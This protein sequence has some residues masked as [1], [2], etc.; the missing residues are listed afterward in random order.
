M[1]LWWV[2]ND[3]D[4]PCQVRQLAFPHKM[5]GQDTLSANHGRGSYLRAN[6]GTTV[7]HVDPPLGVGVFRLSCPRRLSVGCCW[8][9]VLSRSFI[10]RAFA[11][12]LTDGEANKGSD[13]SNSMSQRFC[14]ACEC[15]LMGLLGL[16]WPVRRL[17]PRRFSPMPGLNPIWVEFST[18]ISNMEPPSSSPKLLP[19]AGCLWRCQT[20]CSSVRLPGVLP[21]LPPP[22][23]LL[24]GV[25]SST[26]EFFLCVP[27]I[28]LNSH[29]FVL[30]LTIASPPVRPSFRQ[31]ACS[32]LSLFCLLHT[33]A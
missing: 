3:L 30:K 2:S 20:T 9:R 13:I 8:M 7:A 18:A 22:S 21:A 27:F 19:A 24:L 28:S 6:A 31:V 26:V 14:E 10:T 5:E 29:S 15:G 23:T 25:Q 1:G 16:Q 12:N 4:P 17:G 11:S 32:R 33:F